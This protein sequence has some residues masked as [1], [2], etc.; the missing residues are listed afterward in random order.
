MTKPEI[1]AIRK[2]SRASGSGPW[3]TD[4]AEM[5][6]K[7][8]VRRLFKYLPASPEIATAFEKEDESQGYLDQARVADAANA[9]S[10]GRHQTPRKPSV[11]TAA[12]VAEAQALNAQLAEKRAAQAE[13]PAPANAN[14]ETGDVQEP[15]PVE[16]SEARRAAEEA[17]AAQPPD[18]AIAS[19]TDPQPAPFSRE[20]AV[21]AIIG[22]TDGWDERGETEKHNAL[23]PVLFELKLTANNYPKKATDAQL[24]AI[25]AKVQEIEGK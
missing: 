14:T 17:A 19:S 3:V 21:N 24:A 20:A 7:T 1:D 2:R 6:R 10:A 15:P 23:R 16:E 13:A 22:I 11:P 9:L 5:A 25:L 4:Y 18:G 8:V 12:E